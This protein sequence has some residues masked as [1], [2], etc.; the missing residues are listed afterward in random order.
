MLVPMRWMRR[1]SGGKCRLVN[2]KVLTGMSH[3]VQDRP[4]FVLTILLY[5]QLAV[6]LDEGSECW[7][8][9]CQCRG[10]RQHGDGLQKRTAG[11][12]HRVPLQG[13]SLQA[14]ACYRPSGDVK[15]RTR[16]VSSRL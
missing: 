13:D 6:G 10:G 16:K 14:Q 15:S 1:A 5:R 12:V 4:G 8:V 7:A 3:T 11:C 2:L 9:R